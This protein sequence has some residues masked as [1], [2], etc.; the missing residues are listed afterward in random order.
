L[1]YI[2]RPINNT[3]LRFF[4]PNLAKDSAM[5]RDEK[6]SSWTWRMVILAVKSTNR[7]TSFSC[8]NFQSS[9]TIAS[10]AIRVWTSSAIS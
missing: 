9:V 5:D 3:T 8:S 2:E 1:K 10:I 4:R 7:R 6:Y